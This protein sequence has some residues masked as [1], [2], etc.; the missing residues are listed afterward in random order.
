[1]NSYTANVEYISDKSKI[2]CKC[3]SC[4]WTGVASIL[5][6]IDE[7]VLTPG[8]PSPA[9]RC[10]DCESLTYVLN[11]EDTCQKFDQH[12]EQSMSIQPKKIA[13]TLMS[14][15][16]KTYPAIH[17]VTHDIHFHADL[18]NDRQI[19]LAHRLAQ[20]CNLTLEV[21]PDLQSR[22]NHALSKS[23]NRKLSAS[24]AET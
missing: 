7:C 3:G 10:P 13:V 11:D 5:K 6:P 2:I 8:D 4:E 19:R 14:T 16:T 15:T 20:D 12:V 23:K 17:L 24:S 22:V 18:V 1:M 21:H 9:G